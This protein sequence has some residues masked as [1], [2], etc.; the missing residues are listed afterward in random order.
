MATNPL[1]AQGTLNRLRGSV[2]VPS[3][4]TLNVTS[5]YL[6]K[7]GIKLSLDG[8]T[9]TMIPSMTGT[10]TSPEPYQMASVTIDLLKTNGLAALYKAQMENNSVIGNITVIPDTSALPTYQ[11]INCAIE[12]VRE[13][14]F[15][16]E[17][18]S[19]MV[20]IRGYYIVNNAMWSLT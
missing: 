13:L 2:V 14:D 6:G 8:E 5:P 4:S 1:I 18:A 11:M 12:S 10:V 17:N 7:A 9:T 15:A 20:V 3:F 19:F 16:G